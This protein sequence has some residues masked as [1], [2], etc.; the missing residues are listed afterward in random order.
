MMR[1][2]QLMYDVMLSSPNER[3]C[4][5]LFAYVCFDDAVILVILIESKALH[6]CIAQNK[7]YM[8]YR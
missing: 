5:F 6:T 7:K 2:A 8:R 3:V 1:K 4:H